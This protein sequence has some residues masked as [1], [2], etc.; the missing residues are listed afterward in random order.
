MA[1]WYANQTFGTLKAIR[2]ATPD[3]V[4]IQLRRKEIP[5]TNNRYW[6]CQCQAPGCGKV[7]IIR[8]DNLL[9][10]K[11]KCQGGRG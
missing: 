10:K 5:K 8:S 1:N 11:C 7:Y 6:Y 9:R 3:D 4:R 2:L